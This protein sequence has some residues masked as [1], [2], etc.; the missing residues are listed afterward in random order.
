MAGVDACNEAI[1]HVWRAISNRKKDLGF[2][3]DRA[4]LGANR[5]IDRRR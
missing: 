3:E 4:A 5:G 2:L 1:G